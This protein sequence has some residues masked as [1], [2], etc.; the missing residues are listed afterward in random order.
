M[1]YIFMTVVVQPLSICQRKLD[2]ALFSLII[3]YNSVETIVFSQIL[4]YYYRV[5]S[6][7]EML[8]TCYMYNYRNLKAYIYQSRNFLLNLEILPGV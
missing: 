3:V 2:Q 7:T 6:K 8:V 1:H 4:N 5:E